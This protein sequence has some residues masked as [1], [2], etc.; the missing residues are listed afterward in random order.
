VNI[1]LS[2]AL[3][4]D[5][6]SIPIVRRILTTAM[7]VLGVDTS[8][9]D[10]VALAVTEA[11][12]NVLEH[13]ATGA[14]YE[15]SVGIEEDHCVIEVID[16]GGGFDAAGTGIAT[17]ELSAERGRGVHLMRQMVD[18]VRFDS[19]PENGT[20]VRLEKQLH[21][22]DG[23]PIER[24]STSGNGSTEAVANPVPDPLG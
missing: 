21:W 12:T 14:A 1:K 6:L 17:A 7:N 24:L 20:V 19:R 15:V 4:R 3:P 8:C 22:H 10:E 11:C 23:A 5:E 2:L 9:I 16:T 13:T 18:R